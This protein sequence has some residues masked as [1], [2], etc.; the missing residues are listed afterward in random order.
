MPSISYHIACTRVVPHAAHRLHTMSANIYSNDGSVPDDKFI[1]ALPRQRR[2]RLAP[3]NHLPKAVPARNIGSKEASVTVF[4]L[5][6]DT[7]QKLII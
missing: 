4:A 2:E 3:W 5:V 6:R 7:G 1:V